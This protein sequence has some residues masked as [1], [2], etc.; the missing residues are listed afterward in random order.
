M[1]ILITL[2]GC[3]KSHHLCSQM[4]KTEIISSMSIHG[5]NP[6]NKLWSRTNHHDHMQTTENGAY[7]MH[8]YYMLFSIV[9]EHIAYMKTVIIILPF[10]SYCTT[11]NMSKSQYTH[12]CFSMSFISYFRL[13]LVSFSV[14]SSCLYLRHISSSS[15]SSFFVITSACCCKVK[16]RRRCILQCKH[17]E[18]T[19]PKADW[20]WMPISQIVDFINKHNPCMQKVYQSLIGFGDYNNYILE[21]IWVMTFGRKSVLR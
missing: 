13:L 19:D 1:H 9:V 18:R 14:W 3:V 16:M 15:V 10:F 12:T 8:N 11:S 7:K 21:Q 17:S 4:L 6:V 5:A 2:S 20:K